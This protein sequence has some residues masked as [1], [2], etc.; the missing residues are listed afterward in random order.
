MRSKAGRQRRLKLTPIGQLERPSVK[1]QPTRKRED[2][3]VF[4]IAIAHVSNDSVPDGSEVTP[5]LVFSTA[6]RTHLKMATERTK[7]LQEL[8]ARARRER[9]SSARIVERSID[10][11]LRVRAPKDQ[12]FID[13]VDC[14]LGKGSTDFGSLL[15]VARRQHEPT[16]GRVEAMHRRQ[17]GRS[18]MLTAGPADQIV[19]RIVTC[20]VHT[21]PC[22]FIKDP[23]R[24]LS[25]D[26]DAFIERSHG[27]EIMPA[28]VTDR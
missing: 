20:R 24:S 18:P 8:V 3:T 14:T 12:G 6:L 17:R 11:A 1:P 27:H 26:Q 4:R 22:G 23:E 2:P 13:F 9:A 15:R 25:G 19:G 28:N 5:N 7:R 16:R 10:D 21:K